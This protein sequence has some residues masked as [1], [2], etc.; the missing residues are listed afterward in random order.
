MGDLTRGGGGAN[1][2]EQIEALSDDAKERRNR[3]PYFRNINLRILND[4]DCNT[5]K[6]RQLDG[7]NKYASW[8]Y[9]NP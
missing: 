8:P 2:E 5:L 6:A 1:T 7:W 4:F 9:Q 3:K